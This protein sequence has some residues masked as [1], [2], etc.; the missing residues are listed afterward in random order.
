M[1]LSKSSSLTQ[2]MLNK[3]KSSLT[4][5]GNE[6]EKIFELAN[7]ISKKINQE[8]G[9]VIFVGAGISPEISKTIIDELWFNFQIGKDKFL[10]LTAAKN[11]SDSLE[12]W[13]ELEEVFSVSIFELDEINISSNDMI[14]CLSSSGKTAY[15]V[16]ALKYSKSLG[17]KT[18]L[19]TD[20]KSSE[21]VVY[22]DYIINTNFNDP[23][24]DGLNSAEGGTIQ[25]I[26]LDLLFYNA[27]DISG[28]IYKDKLVYM[29]PIS[30]KLKGYCIDV[31]KELLDINNDLNAND[32]LSKYDNSLELTIICEKLNINPEK[33]KSL[34]QENKFNMNKIL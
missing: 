33:A 19:I 28:R 24:I 32:L 18:A 14:I 21:A 23:I 10:V 12:K 2:R 13:K 30:K 5:I 31:I 11:Y 34:I 9:R 22:A 8:D 6:E 4:F 20:V 15:V 27:M 26:I 25:K 1:K 17:C 7:I 3:I 16:S 29:K